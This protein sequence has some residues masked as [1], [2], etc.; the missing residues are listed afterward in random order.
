MKRLARPPRCQDRSGRPRL[1]Q[2]R[3]PSRNLLLF[4]GNCASLSAGVTAR[5]H[6]AR[7]PPHRK[8]ARSGALR[9]AWARRTR[10]DKKREGIAVTASTEGRTASATIFDV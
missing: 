5:R 1:P 10:D 6:L 7:F 3:P 8:A 9:L 4:H 2:P